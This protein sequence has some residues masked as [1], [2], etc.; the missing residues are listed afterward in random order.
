M[1]SMKGGHNKCRISPY[2]W[3]GV[4]IDYIRFFTIET[5]WIPESTMR[6]ISCY[7]CFE[8]LC[9]MPAAEIVSWSQLS[10][11]QLM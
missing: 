7:G 4:Q 10:T 1:V 3:P 11:E 5:A 8:Y 9:F 2:L 6:T